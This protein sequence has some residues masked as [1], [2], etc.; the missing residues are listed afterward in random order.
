MCFNKSVLMEGL[1][2]TLYK[3]LGV[4]GICCA[5]QTVVRPCCCSTAFILF[6]MWTSLTFDIICVYPAKLKINFQTNKKNIQNFKT[7]P[8]WARRD[9]VHSVSTAHSGSA[10]WWN[11]RR[12]RNPRRQHTLGSCWTADSPWSDSAC[13]VPWRAELWQTQKCLY[14][15]RR[16]TYQLLLS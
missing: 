9:G 6:P 1:A 15:L 13:D 7:Y 11:Y 2:Y 5:N 4:Q 14:S 16:P 8:V 10:F 3:W 12:N